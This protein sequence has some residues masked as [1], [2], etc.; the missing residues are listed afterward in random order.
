MTGANPFD[1]YGGAFLG[2]YAILFVVSLIASFVIAAW[3]RPEG[4]E[5]PTSGEDELAVLAGGKDRLTE[6]VL[7]RLLA[8]DAAVIE[9]GK[10]VFD[11]RVPVNTPVEREIVALSAPASWK[12]I[13]NVVGRANDRIRHDLE[14][15]GLLMEKDEARRLGLFAIMPFAILIA[16]GLI[17]VQV[18]LGRER[19]VGFLIAF[20]IVTAVVALIRL[21]AIDRRTQG[22]MATLKQAQARAERLKL[23]APRDETGMAVALFGTAVLVGSPLA[24][25]HKLRQSDGGSGG[26]DSSGGGD[27]GGSGCGGGGCG[28]CGGG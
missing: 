27:G 14:S 15:R 4:R 10:F 18:G 22:G 2:L 26:G 6:T 1:W 21:F 11:S 24:D 13:G 8:R 16:V 20:M 25:L 19:P 7:S 17:K 9:R 5:V 12:A 3:L 23:A 28:G